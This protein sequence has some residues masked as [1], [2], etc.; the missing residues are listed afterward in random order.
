ME[1]EPCMMILRES[2]RNMK[3]TEMTDAERPR[4]RMLYSGPAALSNTEL[5]A[6]L[7]RCGVKGC[8]AIELA[9]KLL[10]SADGSLVKLY[11]MPM[12]QLQSIKGLGGMKMVPVVAA[13]ELGRRFMAESSTMDKSP[14]V[15]PAQIYRMMLPEMKG[16]AHEE[17][18]V[19]LL[20][21]AN[22]VIHR[23]KMTLGGLSST[24]VDVKSVV[25]L[26]LERKASGIVLVH[27][28]PSGNPRPGGEDIKQTALLKQAACAFDIQLVDHVVV[29]D[30]SY[31]SFADDEMVQLKA[32]CGD[33][34]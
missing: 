13:F 16:L 30:D 4:E 7:L 28:H 1:I 6:I 10:I 32:P 22:Y 11:G 2:T 24:V 15:T 9:R 17:L 21:R 26:A 8:S 34:P 33:V 5:V 3:I 29:C 18:W 27:N 20:N 12:G 14:V 31:F 23:Q 25:A 19:V